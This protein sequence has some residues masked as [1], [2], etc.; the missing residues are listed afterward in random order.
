MKTK[1]KKRI[2]IRADIRVYKLAK[3]KLYNK[4]LLLLGCDT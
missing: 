4:I 3:E 2:K 1:V